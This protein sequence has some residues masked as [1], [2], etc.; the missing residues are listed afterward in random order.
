[1]P[2]SFLLG[3]LSCEAE[4]SKFQAHVFIQEKVAKLEISM[5]HALAF[6]ELESL[7]DLESIAPSFYFPEPYPSF[8]HFVQTQVL[9][10]FQ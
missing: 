8:E 3:N 6:K 7:D 10:K 2:S 9:S 4:I 1:M 5:H